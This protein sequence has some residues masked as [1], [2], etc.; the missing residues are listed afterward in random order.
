M[1]VV[2]KSAECREF[3]KKNRPSAS[4]DIIRGRTFSDCLLLQGLIS[5]DFLGYESYC[6]SIS[7]VVQRRSTSNKYVQN[8]I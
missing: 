6:S 5:G 3:G 8:Q 7:T 4:E 2:G 1:K